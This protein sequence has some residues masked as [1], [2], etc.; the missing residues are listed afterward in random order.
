MK[1]LPS[2]VWPI[3]Y[4]N[5]L[6]KVYGFL[7]NIIKA[8]RESYCQCDL[9][10]DIRPIKLFFQRPTFDPELFLIDSL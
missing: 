1:Q 7:T 6:K 5:I 8:V 9:K 2:I 3:T 10:N 4:Y